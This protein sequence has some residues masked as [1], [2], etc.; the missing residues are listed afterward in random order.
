MSPVPKIDNEDSELIFKIMGVI[1][2][3]F[4]FKWIV[5]IFA[6]KDGRVDVQELQKITA[7]FLFVGAFVYILVKEGE[8]PYGTDHVFSEMWL[9]FVISALLTVLSLEKIF[10]T[11]K[12]LLELAIKLRTKGVIVEKDGNESRKSESGPT[13]A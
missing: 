5:K 1:A 8:R 11:F 4:T 2:A 6:G 3:F 12:Q 9:F 13:I 10:D 7:Y